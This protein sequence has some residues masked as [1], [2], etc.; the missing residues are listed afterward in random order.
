MYA[1]QYAMLSLHEQFVQLGREYKKLAHEL[2]ALLPD[3]YSS[4]I[5]KNYAHSI[6]EYARKYACMAKSTVDIALRLPKK[7]EQAP[8]MLE[9]VRE[10][11]V[12][13]VEIV[14][15]LVTKAN[16]TEMIERVKTMSKPALIEMSKVLRGTR[17]NELKVSLDDEMQ[18]M[19][20]RLKEEFG[21]E[22]NKEA[23]R[24]IFKRA[25]QLSESVKVNPGIKSSQGKT[26]CKQVKNELRSAHCYHCNKP[27]ENIHHVKRWSETGKHEELIGVCKTCHELC[28]NGIL[29]ESTWADQFYRKARQELLA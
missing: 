20:Y 15:S 26:I 29:E 17:S 11:G 24:L 21:V 13:K 3:I 6:Y 5:Y 7:L 10:V 12:R 18:V 23:L 19:F 1:H 27:T 25:S 2:G 28:H 22:S 14:A 16:E 4:G 8:K 9:L